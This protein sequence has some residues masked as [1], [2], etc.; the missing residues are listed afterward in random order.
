MTLK[1][2]GNN[3]MRP[4]TLTKMIAVRT[5]QEVFDFVTEEKGMYSYSSFVEN[6]LMRY[7]EGVKSMQA[8]SKGEQLEE[9]SINL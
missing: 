5:N 7:M 2:G 8:Q 9:I 4:K 1:Y 6:L 3:K